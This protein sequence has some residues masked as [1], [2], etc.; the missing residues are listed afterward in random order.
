[1]KSWITTFDTANGTMTHDFHPRLQIVF[2]FRQYEIS[3]VKDSKVIERQDLT[4]E[5][6][7][8]TDYERMLTQA[9]DAASKLKGYES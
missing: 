6:F 4:G 7:S 5:P 3:I 8:L 2:N 9:A 1:M